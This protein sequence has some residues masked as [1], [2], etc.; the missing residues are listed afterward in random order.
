MDF[1]VVDDYVIG[2][3]VNSVLM[4]LKLGNVS[5]DILRVPKKFSSS[6]GVERMTISIKGITHEGFTHVR[7]HMIEVIP[8]S[9]F[10][11]D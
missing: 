7:V 10:C 6:D 9:C 2:E 1:S 8:Y 5:L 11:F 4:N 3:G